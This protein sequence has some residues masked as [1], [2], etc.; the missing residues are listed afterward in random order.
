[1]KSETA[2]VAPGKS[3]RASS[4]GPVKGDASRIAAQPRSIRNLRMMH[5]LERI[6]GKFNE[7][8]VP[9]MALK[10]AALNL[11]LYEHG[12]ER[13]M[14][15]LDLLIRPKDVDKAFALLEELGG[16]RGD[17]LVREDFF[18]RFHYETEYT[19]GSVYPVKIDLHVRP[20]RPL[21][22]ARLLPPDAFW[23]R[24]A[25]VRITRATVFTPSAEDMLIHLSVHAAVHGYAKRK[26]LVD[27]KRWTDAHNDRLDWDRFLARVRGWRLALPV[28]QAF[29]RVERE[30]GA[31][32]PPEVPSRLS[33][34]AV[35][36]RDR[37]ALWQAPRDADHAVAHVLVNV[38][39]SPGWRFA[40]SYVKAIVIPGQAH[41][42]DWYAH[43]HW[44]WLPCAH[45]VRWL[46]PI[47]SLIP[48]RWRRFSSIETRASRIHGVGVFATR[49]IRAGDIIARYHGRRVDRR[50]RY[51]VQHETSS[52]TAVRYELT[53]KLKYM[54]HSC[55]PNAKITGFKLDALR[56]ISAGH[57]ITIDY[58]NNACTCRR[59]EPDD[60]A[61][62]PPPDPSP[63]RRR[64]V[65]PPVAC[66]PGPD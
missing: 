65:C 43:R 4:R 66:A 29:D 21:R 13:S 22:Y 47:V 35:G 10:G 12:D 3:A 23:D 30:L 52:G 16:L 25:P 41:M 11:T 61:R 20:F 8:G 55:G 62:I 60:R 40:L 18:P 19:L 36:W 64:G 26:W 15:D 58:G 59:S 5:L 9:L 37:L 56:P 45:V 31:L 32:W 1:M 38:L 28:R 33:R 6:A 49:Y 2:L 39:C 27:M 57:E 46:G 44:G 48:K 17:P 24:A 42:A 14:A 63:K 54:N 34:T 51:V 53:G 50:G 7:A